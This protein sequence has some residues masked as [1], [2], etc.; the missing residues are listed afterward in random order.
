M[1]ALKC[2]NPNPYLEMCICIEIVS[3][4]CTI[5]S[6]HV[7]VVMNEP[8]NVGTYKLYL[9]TTKFFVMYLLRNLLFI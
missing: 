7:C 6:A 3:N 4:V 8:R 2:G 5:E 9:D 1:I